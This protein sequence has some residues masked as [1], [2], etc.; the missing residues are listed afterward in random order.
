MLVI[1]RQGDV[2]AISTRRTTGPFLLLPITI[3]GFVAVFTTRSAVH[4]GEH[5][6]IEGQTGGATLV[7]IS[8]FGIFHG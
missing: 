4:R 2:S 3:W 1:S 8:R 5:H 7:F 6:A